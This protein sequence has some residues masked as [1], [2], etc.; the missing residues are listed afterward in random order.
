MWSRDFLPLVQVESVDINWKD[1]NGRTVLSMASERGY[2][3]IVKLLLQ[4]DGIDINFKDDDSRTA[5]SYALI[6][7]NASTA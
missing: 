3:S 4:M 1:H 7:D 5:L 6:D 2:D